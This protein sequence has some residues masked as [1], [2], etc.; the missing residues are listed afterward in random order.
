MQYSSSFPE[1]V[2]VVFVSCHYQKMLLVYYVVCGTMSGVFA[3]N[4]VLAGT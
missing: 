2:L 3:D 1:D 4:Y